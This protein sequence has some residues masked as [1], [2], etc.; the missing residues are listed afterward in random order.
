MTVAADHCSKIVKLDVGGKIFKTSISTLTKHDSMLKTMFLT[1]I[2]VVK[3]EDG[4]IF[5]DRDSQHFRLILNFLRDG[6]MALPDSDREVKEVL[7]E[8]KFFLLD[9]LIELCEERLET[10]FSPYYRVVSTVLEARKYI[11]ATDKPVVVLRLPA[12]I[13]TNGS[14][15]YYFSESKFRSYAEQHYKS[16]IFV[17]ITEPEFH[18]DCSW[19]FFLKTKKLTARIK[20]PMDDNLLEDL[21]RELLIDVAGRKRTDSQQSE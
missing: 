9:P 10:S 8:A 20:G 18:E 19:T 6:E 1:R 5:I 14:Q 12:H 2:P 16:V 13:A 11:F 4:C 17:L 7:A 3:D 15:C 21:F